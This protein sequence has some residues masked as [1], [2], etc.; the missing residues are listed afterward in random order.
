MSTDSAGVYSLGSGLNEEGET[1]GMGLALL[2]EARYCKQNG[3][4]L[5]IC[6]A[7]H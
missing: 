3:I 7:I 4:P 6:I 5:L 1:S 2:T